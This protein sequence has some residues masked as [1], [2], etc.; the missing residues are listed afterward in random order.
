MDGSLRII[1]RRLTTRRSCKSLGGLRRIPQ[2]LL[3][4]SVFSDRDFSQ[5]RMMRKR[6]CCCR[7]SRRST[8]SRSI[9]HT[10]SHTLYTSLSLT[11]THTFLALFFLSVFLFSGCS[12][13]PKRLPFYHSKWWPPKMLR[14]QSEKKKKKDSRSAASFR[15]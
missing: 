15:C 4:Q 6:R 7:L 11:L 3:S 10:H 2:Q 13:L 12:F 8:S 5:L 14:A 9:A 1:G